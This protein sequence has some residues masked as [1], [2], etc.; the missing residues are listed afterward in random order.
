MSELKEAALKIFEARM[1][2]IK[3]NNSEKDLIQHIRILQGALEL[4]K[5]YAPNDV[6]E[7]ID[8][9]IEISKDVVNITLG[10]RS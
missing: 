6:K 4:M 3:I 10:I 8:Q 1:E 5:H 7:L 2:Q 9:H